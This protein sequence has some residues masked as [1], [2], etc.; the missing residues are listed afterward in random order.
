MTKK[1]GNAAVDVLLACGVAAEL[2]CC[3]GLLVMR[4]TSDRLHY[5]AAGYTVGPILIVAALI[6]RE[7]LSSIGLD[8]L[9]ALAILFVPGPIVVHATARVIRRA[10][11]GE[12]GEH[13]LP[14]RHL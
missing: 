13:G 11:S 5:T 9:A 3:L 12:Q 7:G 4:T 6:V 14:E 8:A 10:E 2:L 1:M